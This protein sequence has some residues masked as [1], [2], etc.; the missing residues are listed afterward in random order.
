M[1]PKRF[2]Q[3][4]IIFFV[5]VTLSFLLLN[6]L[7]IHNLFLQI[8]LVTVVGYLILVLPLTVLTVLK[9]KKKFA[10]SGNGQAGPLQEALSKL[11]NMVSL[12]TKG[13]DGAVANTLIA[14]KPSLQEEN[15]WYLVSDPKTKKV[16]DIKENERVALTT[17]FGPATLRLHSNQVVANTFEGVKAVE[18]I[19]ENPEILE[20]NENAGNLTVIQLRFSSIVMESAK[21]PARI[22]SDWS[23]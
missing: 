15:V 2:I 3:L 6:A 16:Q 19:H 10:K 20:L 12:A 18:L 5:T 8:A 1:Y 23:K 14:F 11:P 22:L 9:Q 13:A 17:W 4:F 21:G 7:Q